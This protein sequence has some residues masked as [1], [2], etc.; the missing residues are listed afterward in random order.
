MPTLKDKT[1]PPPNIGE[2]IPPATPSAQNLPPLPTNP[3][4]TPGLNIA[5]LGSAPSIWTTTYDSIRQWIRPGVSQQRFPPLPVKA[6]PQVNTVTRSVV[7]NVLSG[8]TS[9]QFVSISLFMPSEFGVSGSPANATGAFDVTWE[10]EPPN[11][12]LMGPIAAG[13]GALDFATANN[14]GATSITLTVPAPQQTDLV[15][16]VATGEQS[17]ATSQ[18]IAPGAG[19]AS[20]APG[21]AGAGAWWDVIAG[22]LPISE[23]TSYTTSS[24]AFAG[25]TAVMLGIPATSGSAS[26]GAELASGSGFI[27]P[28][29]SIGAGAAVVPANVALIALIQGGDT[30]ASALSTTVTSFSDN[31][32]NTW[33]QVA[34]PSRGGFDGVATYWSV[35]SSVWYCA[36]PVVAS[37][38]TFTVTSHDLSATVN[39]YPVSGAAPV[40]GRPSFR[41]ITLADLPAGVGQL[42]SEQD[43]TPLPIQ[44][45]INFLSP[46][47]GTN[48]P[49]NTSTDVSVAVFKASGGSH[50]KGLVPDPGSSAGT[51]KFLR[52][53]ATWVVPSGSGGGGFGSLFNAGV[54][55]HFSWNQ[56]TG[57]LTIDMGQDTVSAQS[58]NVVWTA[59]EGPTSTTSV[60]SSVRVTTTDTAC[61]Y[62]GSGFAGTPVT[63]FDFSN[64]QYA[65]M[66]YMAR[67]TDCR[68]YNGLVG[69]SS[70]TSS[71]G[72]TS[73]GT[74]V[75][76]A[77]FRFDTTLSDS[78]IMCV[79]CDGTTINAQSSA[80]S[81]DVNTHRYAIVVVPATSVKFYIDYN[82]VATSTTNLPTGTSAWIMTGSWHTSG[83]NPLLGYSMLMTSQ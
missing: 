18:P 36:N 26:V 15:I 72:G 40:L 71:L 37:N 62:R 53:D 50:A 55:N 75:K 5:S 56:S 39:V 29:F 64:L 60:G 9:N 22:G 58:G 48:N 16:F 1:Q 34:S 35:I 49:G 13:G 78:F 70:L 19:W 76:G 23:S 4:G 69:Y 81:A 8:S 31:H 63:T 2:Q 73:L 44:P 3:A 79:T 42:S 10:P 6:N 74:G 25:L 54:T 7:Q 59:L 68:F 45:I 67:I 30:G 20:M 21:G 61:G 24:G 27:S 41:H 77:Y 12:A 57:L 32:S 33:V 47:T 65:C 43:G 66:M 11:T 82:L 28:T 51:T 17:H 38:Y 52:E 46:V 14:V 83:N 80:V